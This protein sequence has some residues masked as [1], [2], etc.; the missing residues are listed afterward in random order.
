MFSDP[1]IRVTYKHQPRTMSAKITVRNEAS[2][3]QPKHEL[4]TFLGQRFPAACCLGMR[5]CFDSSHM[6]LVRV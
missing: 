1:H 3:F 5:W 4:S 2:S 6:Y